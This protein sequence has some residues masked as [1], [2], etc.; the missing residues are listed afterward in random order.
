MMKFNGWPASPRTP[1]D[2]YVFGLNGYTHWHL[3]LHWSP[4]D[5][6]ASP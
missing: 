3:A 5:V 1:I 6:K 2:G 4:I